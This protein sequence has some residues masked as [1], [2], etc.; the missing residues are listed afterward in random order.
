MKNRIF[1]I[2]IPCLYW[3]CQQ[4]TPGGGPLSNDKLVKQY[5]NKYQRA[6]VEKI[7]SF[8]DEQACRQMQMTTDDPVACCERY[9]SHLAKADTFGNIQIGISMAEQEKLF[10]SFSPSTVKDIWSDETTGMSGHFE[11]RFD[12]RFH[13][14]LRVLGE[15]NEK[16]GQY[17]DT[18]DQVGKITSSMHADVLLNFRDYDLF[19]DRVRLMMAVHY[20]TLNRR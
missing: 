12:G 10:A 4:N 8:F 5:F 19:D 1:L 7:L 3:S 15:E 13:R 2:L 9:L 18:F 6:D 17:V 11:I 20:L 16:I 14:F